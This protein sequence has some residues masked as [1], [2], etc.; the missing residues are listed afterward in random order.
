MVGARWG[1][2]VT[3]GETDT[4]TSETLV[5]IETKQRRKDPDLLHDSLK[6]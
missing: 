6:I 2:L 4:K 1:L 3:Q 5:L